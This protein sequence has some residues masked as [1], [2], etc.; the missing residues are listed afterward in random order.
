MIHRRH[1]DAVAVINCAAVTN[2]D[3]CESTDWRTIST[4][5]GKVPGRIARAFPNSA[6]I[7]ISTDY[8]FSGAIKTLEGYTE[9]SPANPIQRYGMSKHMGETN[10]IENVRP[11]QK[12][13]ILRVSTLYGHTPGVNNKKTLVNYILEAKKE[14]PLYLYDQ[15]TNNTLTDDIANVIG[16]MVGSDK[17]WHEIYHCVSDEPMTRFQFAQKI[18]EIFGIERN[19]IC[20]PLSEAKFKAKRPRNCALNTQK[21]KDTFGN[22]MKKPKEGLKMMRDHMAMGGD[23]CKS[24]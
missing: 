7:H 12:W 18:C 20:Q 17:G 4:L 21:L 2:V 14:T 9:R 10:L 1:P 3:G 16:I 23:L 11:S 13:A 8:V 6:I 22:W 19:L 24:Y 5:N 15:I